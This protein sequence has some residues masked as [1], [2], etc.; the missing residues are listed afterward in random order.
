MNI[1]EITHR[2]RPLLCS[3]P[4][5]SGGH[6]LPQGLLRPPPRCLSC[7]FLGVLNVFALLLGVPQYQWL[8]GPGEASGHLYLTGY[9]FQSRLP[10]HLPWHLWPKP[11]TNKVTLLS[12]CYCSL[13]VYI[14]QRSSGEGTC[15]AKVD[16]PC[17][18]G[19][20]SCRGAPS[21]YLDS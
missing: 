9:T 12:H 1:S 10:E 21:C 18:F 15:P 13:R 8:N 4:L 20:H 17:T 2:V 3:T 11:A 14:P 6:A 5:G 16:G 19:Y 7:M